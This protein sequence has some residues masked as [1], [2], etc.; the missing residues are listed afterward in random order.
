MKKLASIKVR[1]VE[2]RWSELNNTYELVKW[3]TVNAQRY[4]Y[5][6]AFF[7]ADSE[8]IYS[9]RTIGIRYF[10]TN[11]D[12]A[13]HE[14]ASKAMMALSNED[15]LEEG[16]RSTWLEAIFVEEM[17]FQPPKGMENYR[18]FRIEY[19]GVNEESVMTGRIWIHREQ[20]PDVIEELLNEGVQE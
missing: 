14:V 11:D 12:E 10:N 16:P 19:G 7:D 6:I 17:V 9:M 20:D 2:F 15:L 1:D 18:S 5:V 3:E 8:G 13:V 4:N